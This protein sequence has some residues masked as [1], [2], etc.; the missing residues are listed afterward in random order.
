MG[1]A[2]ISAQLDGL[3][4]QIDSIDEQI[5]R[6]L[7]ERLARVQ[8][9][10]ALKTTHKLPIYHPAREENLIS[11]RRAQAL[12]AGLDPDHIEELYRSIL[13]QSR[14]KQTVQA[15]K[16]GV[17]P[18]LT[19]LIVG[20]RGKMGRYFE[21]W[22]TESGYQVR[23]LD[24]EDWPDVAP[25]CAGIDLA[26]I[27]VP[28]QLTP[29]VI[30]QLGPY[31]PPECLLADVTSVKQAPVEAMLAAHPGPV[32]GLHPLFGPTTSSMDQQLMAATPGRSP[33]G[34]QW[35]LD[36]MTA[37]GNIVLPIEAREHDEIMNLVQGVRHFATFAFGRFLYHRKIDLLRTLEFS[38]P[39]YRLELGMVGRLF[40]QDASL[41]ANIIFASPER[42]ALLREFVDFLAAD[43][44]L[45]ET[46][47]RE[48]FCAEFERIAQWFGPFCEQAMREST[49]LID[50]LVERF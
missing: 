43:R 19:V 48:R 26:L 14:V 29:T 17:R 34:C 8:K 9:V 36:Q 2:E 15:A 7:A 46:G 50:K 41:Y 24:V 31:L 47:D 25:L 22:F 42:R 49:F 1:K 13:R 23:I 4:E 16:T 30:K 11:Q 45:L 32:I 5:V 39:I 37:W 35:L 27:A 40:A 10:V 18:G 44:D 6:L 33:E 21:R 28:I 12:K 38:S 3:R 20:G